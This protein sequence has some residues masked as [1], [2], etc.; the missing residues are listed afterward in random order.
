MCRKAGGGH[1]TN[2]NAGWASNRV[3]GDSKVYRPVQWKERS[4]RAWAPLGEP[5]RRLARLRGLL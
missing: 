4:A 1:L 3:R 5:R 2:L